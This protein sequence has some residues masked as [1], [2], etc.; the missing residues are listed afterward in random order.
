[1]EPD[2]VSSPH[3]LSVP[4]ASLRPH[5]EAGLGTTGEKT[6]RGAGS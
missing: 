3:P 5:M 1:M 6:V 2:L 4:A